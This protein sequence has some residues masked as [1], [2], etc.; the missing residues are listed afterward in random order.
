M[1]SLASHAA[2]FLKNTHWRD[3]EMIQT[4]VW[5]AYGDSIASLGSRNSRRRGDFGPS[6]WIST[7]D[8]PRTTGKLD[9]SNRFVGM[10]L[11]KLL[12]TMTL[13]MVL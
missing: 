2:K 9:I 11:T 12:Q 10:G 8:I 13:C 5:K 4:A 1:K 3:R 7:R 6:E